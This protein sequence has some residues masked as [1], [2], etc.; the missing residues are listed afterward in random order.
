MYQRTNAGG[1]QIA[2]SGEQTVIEVVPFHHDR[3]S[4]D[5]FD[6]NGLLVI[7]LPEPVLDDLKGNRIKGRRGHRHLHPLPVRISMLP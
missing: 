7:D 1:D 3:R 6:G 4:R 5:G 2:L